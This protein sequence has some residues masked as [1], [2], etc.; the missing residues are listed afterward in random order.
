M[1]ISSIH[2]AFRVSGSRFHCNHLLNLIGI[3]YRFEKKDSV[4]KKARAFV[5]GYYKDFYENEVRKFAKEKLNSELYGFPFR[6]ED[7]DAFKVHIDE[8]Y[9]KWTDAV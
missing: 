9:Q 2:A 8:A 5:I 7:Y 4:K 1:N 6:W 3:H